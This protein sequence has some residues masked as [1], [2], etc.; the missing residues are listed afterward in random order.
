MLDA[1]KRLINMFSD[2]L[3][4]FWHSGEPFL[5]LLLCDSLDISEK[6][7]MESFY[8]TLTFCIL[9]FQS[10]ILFGMINY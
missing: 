9:E 4:D 2:T 7:H 5:L 1:L 3:Q 10:R 8:E 6:Y